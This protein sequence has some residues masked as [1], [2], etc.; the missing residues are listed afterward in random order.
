MLR[1]AALLLAL[2][3]TALL[4]AAATAAPSV[5]VFPLLTSG[6]QPGAIAAAGDGTLWFTEPAKNKVGQVTTDG[7]VAERPTW[8]SRFTDVAIDP[9]LGGMWFAD[10][11]DHGFTIGYAFAGAFL[12]SGGLGVT[13]T[14]VAPTP[15]G[16]VWFTEPSLNQI[17]KFT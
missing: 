11:G 7:V 4:P 8:G 2:G 17:G 5:S 12:G 13:P 14:A 9:T 1:T 15:A 6:A 3:A 16:D 10:E